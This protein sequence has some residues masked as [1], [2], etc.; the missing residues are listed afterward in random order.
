LGFSPLTPLANDWTQ[1]F[2]AAVN[3]DFNFPGGLVIIFELAKELN[4][5][6]NI[7]V[8]QGKTET[9][10]NELLEKWQTLITLAEVLG[11]TAKPETENPVN[12]SLSDVYIE[13]LIQQRQTARKTKNFAESDRIRDQLLTKGITLIDGKEGTRWHR[14]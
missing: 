9:P 13:E 7:I 4:R 5:E 14:G 1:R 10:A 3:D 11:L 8:H 2:E 6:R 12:D